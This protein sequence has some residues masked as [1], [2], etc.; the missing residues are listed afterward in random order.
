[1]LKQRGRGWGLWGWGGE[2]TEGDSEC[3]E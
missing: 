3:R 2:K 1:V